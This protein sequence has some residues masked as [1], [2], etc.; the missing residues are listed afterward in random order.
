MKFTE[1]HEWLRIE[2][3]LV[4]V[5]LTEHGTGNLGELLFVD[6]PEVGE[7]V[8][9]DDEVVTLEGEDATATLMAPVDGEIVEIN[10]ALAD[11][12]GLVNADPIGDGW[13]YRLRAGDL[14][15]L[16]DFMDEDEYLS[17]VD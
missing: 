6:L 11:N 13:L 1:E 15:D 3:D 2:D 14:S 9:Q 5:G 10:E 17:F 8:A 7:T 16:D 4:V 12:P